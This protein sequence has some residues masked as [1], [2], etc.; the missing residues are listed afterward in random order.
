MRKAFCILFLLLLLPLICSAQSIFIDYYILGEIDQSIFWVMTDPN[1]TY[2]GNCDIALGLD[3]NAWVQ[4][5]MDEWL[6][7]IYAMNADP[8]V[9][10]WMDS[11]MGK[12]LIGLGLLSEIDELISTASSLADIKVIL[13][14]GN[15]FRRKIYK[16]LYPVVGLPD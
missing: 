4:D 2:R 13:T 12:F 15:T 5:H 16:A 7:A 6:Q 10:N 14:K 3:P 8:N 1:G 11:H 9:P